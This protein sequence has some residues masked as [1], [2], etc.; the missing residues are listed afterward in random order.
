MIAAAGLPAISYAARGA[1]AWAILIAA[2]GSFWWYAQRLEWS[3]V[4]SFG[5]FFLVIAAIR[6]VFLDMKAWWLLLGMVAAISAWD[7]DYFLSRLKQAGHIEKASE[8]QLNHLKILMAV[9]GLGFFFGGLALAARL[10]LRLGRV[11]F[12]G[13]IAL[14]SLS[15]LIDFFSRERE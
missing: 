8:F 4:G 6:G 3:G 11:L 12:L 1:W 2:F 13:L 7:L 5:L 14:L 15:K 9:A 10:K